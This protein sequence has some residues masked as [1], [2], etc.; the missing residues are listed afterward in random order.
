MATA[1]VIGAT[2]GIGR[3]CAVR[4]AQ[5]GFDV[6]AT[7]RGDVSRL[8]ELGEV[9]RKLGRAFLALPLDVR[10]RE[11]AAKTLLARFEED[12]PDAVVLNAGVAADNLFAWMTGEEWDR[13]LRTDLD[14]F[15]NAIQPLAGPMIAARKGCIVAIGSASGQVGRAGQVNY[16]AAKAGLIGA[17]KALAQELGRR[18]IRANLVAPGVVETEMTKDLP[19]DKILPQ[20]PLRRFGRPEDVAAAV[21]FLVSP[22]AAY[23][24]GQ[25]LAVNGG[26]IV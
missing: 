3:A 5:D 16:S 6:V 18:G 8:A 9:V 7:C 19:K 25:V 20:I 21:S 2:R 23:V 22:A 10:E 26:L 12:P 13:V 4:L 1:L 14:G 17:I 11:E 24:T 15:Y